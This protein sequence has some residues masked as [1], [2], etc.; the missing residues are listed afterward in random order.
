MKQDLFSGA[1]KKLIFTVSATA[2]AICPFMLAA[3]GNSSGTAIEP[4]ATATVAVDCAPVEY[5]GKL[6]I[7]E[8]MVKNHASV[9]D[10]NGTFPDWIELEN[11]SDESIDLNGLTIADSEDK[12]GWRIPAHTL[13]AGERLVIYADST[14]T[15]GEYFHADFSL[16]LDETVILR[17]ASGTIIDSA[18][19]TTDKADRALMRNANGE[20]EVT[21]FCTPN[22]PNTPAGYAAWQSSVSTPVGLIISEV[23]VANAGTLE[24]SELGLCDWVE[25]KNNSSSPIDLGNYRLSDDLGALEAYVLPS[26]TLNSGES[27]IV[28]CSSK[29]GNADSGYLRAEFDLNADN[30]RLYLSDSTGV[31]VDYAYLHDIPA[32][33][34]YGRIDGQNGWFYFSEPHPMQTKSGG[35][36]RISAAPESADADGVFNDITDLTVTLTAADGAEIYYTLDAS[37]PTTASAKYT[38]PLTL[39]KTTVVRAIAV[40]PDA[41]PSEVLTLSFIINEGHTLPVVSLTADDTAAFKRM[42]NGGK[43]DIELAG[44]IALYTDEGSFSLPCGIDMHGESSLSLPKKNMGIHFRARYGEDELNYD[45]FGG[46]E[47]SFRA[48]I[49]RAG[50]DQTTTIIRSELLENLCLQY[51]S[52]VPTQRSE[53]CVVYLNGEY[54]GIYALMEKVN[55]AHYAKLYDVTR[56]SVTVTKAPAY[57]GSDYYEEVIRFAQ[58][59]DLTSAESYAKFCEI[60]DID[61]LIDWMIIEGYS[62][63]TDLTNGNLRYARST[64]GDG[65]WRFMLY[66]LDSTLNS[67]SNIFA[68]VLKPMSTQCAAFI[69]PLINNAEFRARFLSRASE[70]LS[71][72]LSN[73][74][75]DAEIVRLSTLIAPEIER[76]CQF[77]KGTYAQWETAILTLRKSITNIDWNSRCIAALKQY[78]SLTPD[79]MTQ[80]FGW[81]MG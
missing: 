78:M 27:V 46:G 42:Y 57:S 38:H 64:E 25:L 60:V 41:L 19:C 63:N 9:M 51:S 29:S 59:N 70:V 8:L 7:S 17:D 56:N 28:I 76:N 50:Q 71:S 73:E 66:D 45:I 39:D 4:T 43:K 16:S 75:V 61:S 13:A 37:K 2:L 6:I 22:Y 21:K 77:S 33:G 81:A 10:E 15:V 31:V 18:P 34:S 53:Y 26:M 35:E 72:T 68:N 14:D 44:N 48:L 5:A 11:I 49:L 54:N 12:D 24:Q 55:E 32:G 69:S 80:Y 65:K 47:T 20:W 62:G 74:N 58:D 36:R 52:N 30:E 23:V 1:L 79:E 3:C 40:E 67:P